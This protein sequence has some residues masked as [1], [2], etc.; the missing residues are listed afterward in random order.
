MS[1]LN[2]AVPFHLDN[3]IND[4][5]QEF[6]LKFNKKENSLETLLEFA[7]KYGDTRLNI[8]FIGPVNPG[9]ILAVRRVNP[10]TYVRL[11]PE[12]MREIKKLQEDEIKFFFNEEYPATS[13]CMLDSLI[14]LGVSDVYIAD[15]LCYNLPE[16]SEYCHSKDVGIRTILNRIPSTALNRSFDTKSIVYRPQDRKLLSNYIDTFE[17][18]CGKKPYD[19]AKFDVLYRAWFEREHWHGNIQEINDDLDF[20]FDNDT[21]FPRFTD[22]KINCGRRCSQRVTNTCSKC[23]QF[24]ELAHILK[25]KGVAL[26]EE[27]GVS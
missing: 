11:H 21:V 15:D 12:D 17:F 27:E 20:G 6:N 18:D 7:E 4:V 9:T 1:K 14:E 19:W 3:E 8:E 10:E 13:L 5:V 16:V 2:L 24:L 26:T 23:S 22:Y 25:S